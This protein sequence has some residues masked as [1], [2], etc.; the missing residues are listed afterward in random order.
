M[1]EQRSKD[2]LE[3]KTLKAILEELVERYGWEEMSSRISI[4]CFAM[5][6]SVKSS[7]SFLRKTPWARNKVENLYLLSHGHKEL[8]KKRV[9]AAAEKRLLREAAE[10]ENQSQP[11]GGPRGVSRGAPRGGP[12]GVSRGAP[13]GAPRSFQRPNRDVKPK[14]NVWTGK[15]FEKDQ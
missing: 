8:V 12:R 13:R 6:P 14:V 9:E 10:K 15:P 3:G 4:N 5:N 2:P 11:R 7:L 1:N